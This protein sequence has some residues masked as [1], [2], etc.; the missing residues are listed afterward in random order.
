[1]N[2]PGY[3]DGSY[4]PYEE[5]FFI[6]KTREEWAADWCPKCKERLEKTYEGDTSYYSFRVTFSRD[7]GGC[8]LYVYAAW[9][10]EYSKWNL[11]LTILCRVIVS[12]PW[13]A[14]ERL[15]WGRPSPPAGIIRPFIQR[16]KQ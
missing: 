15:F 1:M 11:K 8:T 16:F 6:I 5:W 12:I 2:G 7:Y 9:K 13:K 14:L 10:E 3:P 4:V